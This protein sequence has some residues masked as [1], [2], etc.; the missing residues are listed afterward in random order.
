V[1]QGTPHKARDTE[2]FIE[3]VGKSPPSPKFRKSE[4]NKRET[5]E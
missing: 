3:K 1:Y 4:Q 5:T 2:T